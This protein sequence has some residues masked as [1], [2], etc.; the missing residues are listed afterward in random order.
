MACI[1]AFRINIL[2]HVLVN[3]LSIHMQTLIALKKSRVTQVFRK[4]LS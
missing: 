2:P 1:I 4:E 3:K